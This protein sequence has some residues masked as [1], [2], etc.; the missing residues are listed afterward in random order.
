MSSYA[1]NLRRME[2]RAMMKALV[3]HRFG[4][5]GVV[6]IEEVDRPELADDRVLIRVRASSINKADMHQLTGWPRML[7]PVTRNGILRPKSPLLGSDVAGVVEAVG[8]DVTGL[9]VGD[10][11]FGGRN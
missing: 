5:P 10:A 9:A 6:R 7:R 2:E 1:V 4:G 3:R 8:K 11:V